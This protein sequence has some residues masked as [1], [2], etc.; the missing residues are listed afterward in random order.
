[1]Q[2][3]FYKMC[4][5]LC[6]HDGSNHQ[7]LNAC[8]V[9]GLR[10]KVLNAFDIRISSSDEC[11]TNI[12]W[13]CFHDTLTIDKQQMQYE[14]DKRNVLANQQKLSNN[15]SSSAEPDN[16][17][18]KE[19]PSDYRPLLSGVRENSV[20]NGNC[21]VQTIVTNAT[22][23]EHTYEAK[24]S[25]NC[26]KNRKKKT[27]S[28]P[29][30]HNA[31]QQVPVQASNSD[32]NAIAANQAGV[33]TLS[34]KSH[35]NQETA[36][37]STNNPANEKASYL[38]MTFR[39]ILPKP[40]ST[41]PNF[42]VS[43]LDNR[44]NAD[45]NLEQNNSTA[46]DQPVPV[47]FVMAK[48]AN[49]QTLNKNTNATAANV[50][51]RVS[52]N[53]SFVRSASHVTVLPATENPA[54]SAIPLVLVNQNVPALGNPSVTNN[55]VA[56]SEQ[57]RTVVTPAVVQTTGICTESS[58][59]VQ[60]TVQPVL[61]STPI[62]L[63]NQPETSTPV[64]LQNMSLV[65]PTS[66]TIRRS[67][68][69]TIINT[70]AI[71]HHDSAAAGECSQA[72]NGPRT[73]NNQDP[74]CETNTSN[75]IVSA[76][77][78]NVVQGSTLL[79]RAL[80]RIEGDSADNTVGPTKKRRHSTFIRVSSNL[81]DEP[82]EKAQFAMLKKNILLRN[83]EHQP[84]ALPPQVRIT[85]PQVIRI[86]KNPTL[87]DPT[88]NS[89]VSNIG[90]HY[91]MQH[92]IGNNIRPPY[93][94]SVPQNGNP[95]CISIPMRNTL[96]QQSVAGPVQNLQYAPLPNNN[97]HINSTGN[98][99]IHVRNAGTAAGVGSVVAGNVNS[100]GNER[101][102]PCFRCNLCSTY[103]L[104]DHNLRSHLQRVH[105][106]LWTEENCSMIYDET[107]LKKLYMRFRRKSVADPE[108]LRGNRKQAE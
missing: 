80:A 73:D 29:A 23:S 43:N 60:N 10:T 54:Q 108:A 83:P 44:P 3:D 14:E 98:T 84:S 63:G 6:L 66:T 4:C 87:P 105:N 95:Y 5:R 82:P 90:I 94:P 26:S 93:T 9:K 106:A 7:L 55:A 101:I 41:H 79:D 107:I 62:M 71:A 19:I 42:E 27:A 12:C 24:Q 50:S 81:F 99:V 104:I 59:R 2:K 64:L 65:T 37:N 48:I 32:A 22:S 75:T 74:S 28:A 102:R 1:M 70:N 40:P 20:G 31:S 21:N 89:R 56:I 25:Q 69:P 85:F 58:V 68:L 30:E 15:V 100:D 103:Y 8:S 77:N 92:N 88:Q 52:V 86:Q 49:P 33:A 53:T 11:S 16:H 13:S 34:E 47:P 45:V 97:N 46:T 61:G 36:E 39:K 91:P 35:G 76:A 67:A 72:V 17:C 38:K 51:S 96:T 57:T 78:S 18:G